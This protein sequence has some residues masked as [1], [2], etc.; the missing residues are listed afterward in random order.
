M[1]RKPPNVVDT[2]TGEPLRAVGDPVQVLPNGCQWV[3]C[4]TARNTMTPVQFQHLA[5]LGQ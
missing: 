4:V 1:K 3:W 2:R 5:R